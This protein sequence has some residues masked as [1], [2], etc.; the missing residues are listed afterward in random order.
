MWSLIEIFVVMFELRLTDGRRR[1]RLIHP[2]HL[3]KSLALT[4]R[5]PAEPIPLPQACRSSCVCYLVLLRQG[6]AELKT[7][8]QPLAQ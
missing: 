8:F 1:W 7:M 2:G 6:N 5:R 4:V 3:L